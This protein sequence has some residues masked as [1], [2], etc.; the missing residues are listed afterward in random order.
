MPKVRILEEYC[1]GCELCVSACPRKLLTLSHRVN[2]RGLR[3]VAKLGDECSG[4]CDCAL[5][6][7]D[8]AIEILDEDQ[9]DD[10]RQDG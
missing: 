2:R 6:C 7:P 9:V 4:C 10:K 5:M 3:V 8:A 1:K